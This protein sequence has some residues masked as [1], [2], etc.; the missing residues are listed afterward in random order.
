[1]SIKK[2]IPGIV[3][4]SLILILFSALSRA[5]LIKESYAVKTCSVCY[6]DIQYEAYAC[7]KLSEVEGGDSCSLEGGGRTCTL[8]G[9]CTS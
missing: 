1:M 9:N 3:A 8:T 5:P 6:W 2:L 4:L 7:L